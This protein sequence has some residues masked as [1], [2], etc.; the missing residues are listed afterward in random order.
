MPIN[1]ELEVDSAGTAF[2]GYVELQNKMTVDTTTGSVA[3]VTV[4]LPKATALFY[5]T[6]KDNFGNPLPGVVAVFAEDNNNNGNGLYQADGYTDTNGNYTTAAVGGLGGN[7]TWNVSID[8]SSSF[9][10]YIFSQPAFDQNGG[11][12]ISVGQA[13]L[14]NFTAILVTNHITGNVKFNGTN[15]VGVGVFA[16][17]TISGVQ[18]NANVDTDI[19]GNYSFNVANGA[20]DVGI[21]QQGGD[22][23]LDNIIGNGNYTPPSDQNVNI[24]NNNGVAN[25]T[26]QGFTTFLSGQVV[27]D[28]ENPVANMNVFA[29]TNGGNNF[30]F[31][32]TTDSGGNFRM[33]IVGGNYT[34]FLNNDP[35][36]GY[37][38]LNLVGPTVPV[39]ITDGDNINNFVLVAPQV[40]GAIQVQVNDPSDVGV[41]GI[42]VFATPCRRRH[43]LL[44]RADSNG[45]F[46]R[47]ER[48]GLQWHMAGEPERQRRAE[49]R[50]LDASFPKRHHL[51]Q[52]YA[53]NI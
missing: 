45:R 46:G 1:G 30:S 32:A 9:P 22:D 36:S 34:L 7:D 40:T 25:F 6:V 37:P 33:G 19:N 10:N 49:R 2:A 43:Q 18:Y 50:L 26:I 5:G 4:A 41:S 27:D 23:S 47:G 14:A 3:G 52:Q 12:N 17:A 8:N 16:N 29:M 11:T 39:S 38:S 15:L 20:W 35:N 28:S 13:V 51:Q 24:T 21:N 48:A 44:Q 31:Q 42:G 53:G